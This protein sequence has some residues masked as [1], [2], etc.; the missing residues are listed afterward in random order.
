MRT[1]ALAIGLVGLIPWAVAEAQSRP[2][3]RPA[4]RSAPPRRAPRAQPAS[5]PVRRMTF[6]DDDVVAD[7]EDGAGAIVGGEK[8]VMFSRLIHIR[9]DFIPELVKSAED[10]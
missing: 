3:L 6:G 2:P 9:L 5:P 1:L 7:R 4:A 8:R 10:L